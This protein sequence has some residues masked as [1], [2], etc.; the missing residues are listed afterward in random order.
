MVRVV[1]RCACF[2]FMRLFT[3]CLLL[4]GEASRGLRVGIEPFL[5][6]LQIFTERGEANE[7]NNSRARTV[8][9][10]WH[11]LNSECG[12]NNEKI[13]RHTNSSN[14]SKT[15]STHD[16]RKKDTRDICKTSAIFFS[17]NRS[18]KTHEILRC[19]GISIRYQMVEKTMWGKKFNAR[20]KYSST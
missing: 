16:V 1:I 5:E 17:R 15:F 18:A 13:I 12:V 14:F 4:I 2:P 10:R 19:N 11:N 7:G 6:F 9:I 8:T 20:S 3:N